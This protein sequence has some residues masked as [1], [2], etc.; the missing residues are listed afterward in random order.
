MHK[1][2]VVI[3]TPKGNFCKYK[4]DPKEKCFRLKKT[5]PTGLFF[6]YD[7]GFIPGTKGEDGDP[8]D[9]LVYSSFSYLQG[10]Y[11]DCLLICTIKAEQTTEGKTV[12]N[13]RF[14]GIP[15]AE[16]ETGI[17]KGQPTEKEL[18]QLEN[19]FINYNQAV[20]KL[21]RPLGIADAEESLQ[22]LKHQ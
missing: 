4:F 10:S 16:Y 14:I 1:V 17:H 2:E 9:I 13:D 19:F 15:V 20:N 7:F 18:K 21:F 5:L 6:P 11:I 22:I 8:L 3:E 12:R